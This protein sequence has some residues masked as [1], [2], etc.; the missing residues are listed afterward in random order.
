MWSVATCSCGI[1]IVLPW[2]GAWCTRQAK[3]ALKAGKLNHC[4]GLDLSFMGRPQ[5]P[6]YKKTLEAPCSMGSSNLSDRCAK[7]CLLCYLEVR[8]QGQGLLWRVYELGQSGNLPD[9]PVKR[10]GAGE[11]PFFRKQVYFSGQK[12]LPSIKVG[13]MGTVGKPAVL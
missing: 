10:F 9:S 11:P 4:W 2:V 13:D 12:R 6:E 8:G 1:A 5:N 3:N 7:N